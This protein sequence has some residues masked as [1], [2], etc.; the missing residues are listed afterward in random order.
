MASSGASEA[1]TTFRLGNSKEAVI[2]AAPGPSAPRLVDVLD[3]A[4]RAVGVCLARIAG[5]TTMSR[6]QW[7]ALMLLDDGV[8]VGGTDA[9][10]H[11]MGEIAV[12][13]A[14]PAPTATRMVDK[15]VAG[16][17]AFRRSDPWDR[18]RVLV[19]VSTEGHSLVTRVANDIDEVF[20][21]VRSALDG[22]ELLG[23]LDRLRTAVAVQ[24][25]TPVS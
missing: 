9:P 2:D 5:T 10:G 15:L 25:Q 12:R 23:L 21:T 7:R 8:G 6:E 16:G 20:G 24:E 17:L 3:L 19:H 13:A 11:T 18:R 14:V 4:D 22:G 1:F